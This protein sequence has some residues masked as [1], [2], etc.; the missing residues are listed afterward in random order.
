MS[1][2][3]PGTGEMAERI[4]SFGWS[5]TALGPA[6]DWPQS[7]R[8]AV[9]IMLASGH[10]MQLAWGHEGIVLYNDAYTPM[11]GNHH[12]AALGLPFHAAWPDIWAEIEPLVDRVFAGETV[13]FEDMPLVMTRHGYAE[14]TWWNFSYSPVRDESGAVAGLLNVTVDASPK[15]RA[16]QAERE[17]DEINARLGQSVLRFRALATAGGNSIYRMSPDWRFMYELDSQTLA[18]TSGPLAHWPQQYI[19]EEDRPRVLAAIEEAIRTKSLFELEH[20]V[21]L[22]DGSVGW[23]LSRAVPLLD[24]NGDIF[25]WFGAGTDVSERKRAELNAAFLDSVSADL[26]R[27]STPQE[28]VTIAAARIG[29]YLRLSGCVFADVAEAENSV[30]AHVGWMG[31]GVPS[32][33]ERTFKLDEYVTDE[34]RRSA[35]AGEPFLIE[36]TQNDDRV[37]A[38]SYGALGVGA[39]AAFHFLWHGRWT[40]SLAVT[41]ARARRWRNDEIELLQELS[42]RIFLY[43]ERARTEAAARESEQRQ[44]F[45]LKLSDALRPLRDAAEIQGMACRVLGE[46]LHANRVCYVE[47]TPTESIVE[48]D[49]TSGVGSLVGRWKN[50][51]FGKAM[52]EALRRERVQVETDLDRMPG[53]SEAERAN[54][55]AI[56]VA[57]QIVVTLFK[58]G[59]WIANFGVH[60]ATPREWTKLEMA[61]AEETAERTWAAVERARAE[62]ALR[63]SERTLRIA[64]EAGRMGTYRFDIKTGIEQWSDAEYEMLGLDKTSEPPTRELFRSIV[65][66]EDLHRVQFGAD[67]ARPEGTPLDTE[68][69]IIRPDTGEVRW[70]S[71]HALAVFGDDGRPTELIGVNLDITEQRALE[72]AMHSTEERLREF[73]EASSDILWIRRASDLQWEYLSPAFH[74]VYGISRQDALRGDN[75]LSWSELI[76]PEDRDEALAGIEK[77][78]QGERAAFEYRVRRP[79]DG[80]IR[81]LRNTDFPMRDETGAVVRIGGIGHDLTELKLAEQHQK[82]LLAELQHRVRNTFAVI[83]SV[84]RRTAASSAS[85][86]D[87][88]MHLEGRI[89]AFAR[90]QSVVTRDPAKG[91]D[92]AY[93]LGEELR[94]LGGHE[95]RG[96]SMKGPPVTLGP[97]AAQT[98][99][100]AVHELATN[101]MKH[102]ALSVHSGRID[103]SWSLGDGQ[104]VFDWSER[105]LTDLPPQPKRRGFGTEILERTLAYELKAAAELEFRPTGLH[106]RIAIPLGQLAGGKPYALP[107]A[108]A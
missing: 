106:C 84:V 66:P 77:V 90:V 36:D 55:R 41:D 47:V 87:Y 28:I 75:L 24:A 33:V 63:E 76:V 31:D 15:V 102:G 43:R 26:G 104:F 100:L 80:Q 13:R 69:R 73:G 92:L 89:D 94:L 38:D 29:E 7:L 6:E 101:A 21:L 22:A 99:G 58:G 105:G 85:L 8:T 17:R 56:E 95:G 16:R 19:L 42:D 53:L 23:V 65:H 57:A 81:W 11:L 45:L 44:A 93:L 59:R 34:L 62:A 48:Q 98:F 40:N 12:P 82:L 72:A 67:D 51:D 9:E 68:F 52:L 3:P 4:R 2:W 108:D 37:N 18:N 14:D 86:E 97:K 60:S 91:V 96:L 64:L 10:A 27:Q 35:H 49:Y 25:E 74:K 39:V 1:T 20:R 50:A 107:K 83:R 70:I 5:G 54:Y 30:I 32:L 88:V 71:A 46:H 103:V 79:E 78:R 61:L